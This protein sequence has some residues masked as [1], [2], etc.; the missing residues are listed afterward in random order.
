MNT[1]HRTRSHATTDVGKVRRCSEH[2]G[3]SGQALILVAITFLVLLAFVGLTTDVGQLLIYVG[4]LRRATDAASLAAAAQYREGRTLLEMTAAAA[5]VMDLNGVD[6]DDY[7]VTVDT[8]ETLPGDPQLCTTPRRK[9]VRV[10]SDLAVPMSFLNLVGVHSVPINANSIGEAASLDVVLVIDISESMVWDAAPGAYLRDPHACNSEDPTGT[11]GFKGECQPF[12]EVK[13]SAISFVNRVLNKPAALEEDRLQIVT[14]A[15]GWDPDTNRGTRYRFTSGSSPRWTSD[16]DEALATINNL[17]VYDPP[18]CFDPRNDPEGLVHWFYGPCRFY[19]PDN[20]YAFLD[21]LSCRA[22]MWPEP[23]PA[24]DDWSALTTTNIGGA[25]N[26]AGNMFATETRED[27]LWV[28]VLLTDGMANATFPEDDDNITDYSSYPIGFCPN[29]PTFPLC[30]DENVNTRHHS[31]DAQYDADDYARD[32]ADFVGCLPLNTA[33]ACSGTAGQGAV[34]F[35]IGLG[36]GVIDDTNEAHGRPY[37]A[38]L[39]R[40]IAAVGDDG[41]PATDLCSGHSNYAEWCGNYYFSPEGP[42]LTRVFEDI[43]SRIFTRL[44]H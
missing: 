20:S 25:L 24:H 23:Q 26:M 1:G 36:D 8:C 15:N 29:D 12:E 38:S 4:H 19:N 11:D 14:F 35:T 34:I 2:R 30:Q 27:A 28:V 40:Y 13:R 42:G 22:D 41:D 32:M 44:V 16:R 10:T 17:I 3:E 33:A 5:Q 39:L 9:L 6:P 18:A 37:G 7:T 21:C 43:A 31:G